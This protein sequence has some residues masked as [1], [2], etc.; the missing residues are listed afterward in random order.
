MR[1]GTDP[2]TLSVFADQRWRLSPA[3]FEG[4]TTAFSIDFSP[5]TAPFLPTVKTLI[6]L[7]LNHSSAGVSTFY[8]RPRTLAIPTITATFRNLRL[9]TDWLHGRGR[10][11][12]GEVSLADLDDY[13]AHV[14]AAE[15]SHALREDRLSI[16][17]RVWSYRDLLPEADRLP[18]TPPW[19]GERIQDILQQR[20]A[21]R[22]ENR[23]PRIHPETMA[24]LLGWALRFVETFAADI[25]AAFDEHLV[26][27][28]RSGRSRRGR[29][30]P[31]SRRPKGALTDDLR[32]LL[33]DYR[34]QGRPLPGFRDN[35]GTLRVNLSHLAKVLD[36]ARGALDA[37]SNRAVFA[38]ARLP[39]I[40]GAPL[41]APV[42]GRL[43]GWPWHA[44]TIEYTEAGPLTRH[45]STACFIVISYLS[46]MSPG[47][48]LSLERG[49]VE[50][51]Q[52]NGLVLLRGRHWKGVRDDA[53]DKRPEGEIRADPWVVTE[54]VATA[55]AVLERLHTS[56]WLFPATLFTDGRDGAAML[57]SRVG[58]S[59]SETRINHDLAEFLAWVETYCSERGRGD[60]IPPDPVYPVIFSGRLR[61]TLAWFIVRRPRGLVAAAIQYGHLRVQM[62]LGY[63]GNY[64]SGF[65]DDLAFEDW[66]ARLD[67]LADAHQRLR[68]GELVSGPA[69]ETYRYRVQA[70]T[71]FAGRVLRTKR[72]ANAMLANPDLQIFPGKGMTCVLDP[73][74]AACRLRSEEDSTRRTPD[75]DD[76]RPNCVNIARTDRDIEQV[77]VQIEQLRPLVDDPLAPAFRHVREQHELDRLERIVTAHA[78]SGELHDD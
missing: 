14:K 13:A 55:V 75:L 41:D 5:V 28:E 47:E 22:E 17:N 49:C 26:L 46:G 61:R 56:T 3:V 34:E 32:A 69:A 77:H 12:F 68:E 11:C 15:S 9:F 35:D 58:G 72:H 23:T 38:E 48:V 4:H 19:R 52:A 44:A 18:Q 31:P 6:W 53:G 59:R 27:S 8:F 21:I 33:A 2:S 10:T 74:R 67:T 24:A 30:I 76:C 64:A 37:P 51:D 36:T 43:D 66:L 57:R 16:V 50:R 25:T 62:T 7:L 40:E 60:G 71:R 78:N 42:T 73:K 54:V 20:R 65:P 70:A 63:A 29:N 1:P 45:L 39:V